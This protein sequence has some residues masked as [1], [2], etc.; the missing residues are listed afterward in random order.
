MQRSTATF[1]TAALLT[2]LVSTSAQAQFSIGAKTNEVNGSGATLFSGF[3]ESVSQG[4]DF[5]DMDG[6]GIT[7]DLDIP[8]VDLVFPNGGNPGVY[9]TQ[10]VGVGSGNGF[11]N[12]VD[13]GY[14][15]GPRADFFSGD[16]FTRN[17]ITISNTSA[18]TGEWYQDF[19]AVDVPSSWFVTDPRAGARWD[20]SP[21]TPANAPTPGY[22]NSPI[23]SNANP[24]YSGMEIGNSGGPVGAGGQSNALKSL[25][26]SAN[27]PGS[28]TLNLNQGSPDRQTLFDT[29]IAWTP[30]A[31]IA[32][33]GAALDSDQ[34]GAIDG[35]IRK[36]EQQH[37]LAA[38]RLPSGENLI[39]VTRDSG[40]GTR[41]G[42][43]NSLG[44]DPSWAAGENV[45][46]RTRNSSSALDT[47]LGPN[48]NPSNKGGSSR[49]EETVRHARLA[50]GYTGLADGTSTSRAGDDAIDGDYMLIAVAN[51][52][53]SD[54][55]GSSYVF[56][57][58]GAGTANAS[59]NNVIY[60]GDTN[61]GWQ[62]GGSQTFVTEG[63]PV[64]GDIYYNAT[65][66]ESDWAPFAGAVLVSADDDGTVDPDVRM[67]SPQA[68][69]YFRN[70][71][72]SLAAAEANTDPTGTPGDFLAASFGLVPATEK[73][74]TLSDTDIFED[75]ADL[76]SALVDY[77]AANPN[78][79][80]SDVGTTGYGPTASNGNLY[81]QVPTR[82]D[83]AAGTYSDGTDGSAGYSSADG[84][85]T[86]LDGADM[87]AGNA[88]YDRNAIAG[89]FNNDGLRTTADIPGMVSA[90]ENRA[91]LATSDPLVSL[92]LM[93]DFNADGNYDLEDVRYAADG[94]YNRGRAGNTLDRK[95]NYT[96]IDNASTSGNVFGTSLATG[97]TYAAGDSRGDVAAAGVSNA[98]G[99]A[100]VAD[101]V[102]D[103]LDIDYVFAQMAA[104]DQD[105]NGVAEWANLDEAVFFDL[106]ADMDGDLDVDMDD[107]TE[108]VEGI[109]GTFFGDANLDGEV[110]LLDLDALGAS[111]NA[112]GAGW[113]GGDFNGDGTTSLLDL[114]ILGQNWNA[115]TSFEAA[116]AA[117]GIAV[118]EPASLGL[119]LAGAGLLARR[120]RSAC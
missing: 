21:F 5:I 102:V 110:G 64:E 82:E 2:A 97:K 101:G 19:A 50:V 13:Y 48:F 45:G 107:A 14:N 63:N 6:D 40:S 112:E 72:E 22:G 55:D 86:V 99:W 76:S 73:L 118:P 70:I 80:P 111:W 60:N 27:S 108:L 103:S 90:L 9:N 4:S 120:R 59:G 67:F 15:N 16:P 35:T 66:G 89:D 53:S 56:P 29:Q 52:T 93:A 115:G 79:L 30:I 85:V 24:L 46:V 96:E 51:D 8:T 32:N 109:L 83:L 44:V 1:T 25:P 58:Y 33:Y 57:K 84:S 37:L 61:T 11:Q 23:A 31:V 114:D 7:T 74:P 20:A 36:T 49:M 98:R 41:N 87:D 92:E 77:Y 75:N 91:G 38:G 65:T 69:L 17:G 116:L 88:F 26:P 18:F 68:A 71:I 100:P 28:T 62:I 34:S 105:G 39:Q 119:V 3:F 43:S 12:L 10:Y 54:W 78:D 94:L 47:D 104:G 95:A 117:S 42:F 106:S 113:S 81:G